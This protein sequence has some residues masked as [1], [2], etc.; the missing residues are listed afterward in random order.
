MQDLQQLKNTKFGQTK[1]GKNSGY[2]PKNKLQSELPELV[3]KKFG[4]LRVLTGKIIRKESTGKAQ[5]E[6]VCTIC[7][8][9]SL[10]DYTSLTTLHA[11]CRKCAK[12]RKIPK[13]LMQRCISAKQRCTNKNDKAYSRYGAREIKFMF[14]SPTEMGLWIVKN[15]GL[16]KTKQIDRIDNN[17]NYERGNLRLSTA[18]QNLCHTQKKPRSP[19]IHYIR[20]YHK[21]IKYADK[22]ITKLISKGFSIK[23]IAERQKKFPPNKTHAKFSTLETP[24]LFIASQYKDF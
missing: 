1:D 5:L 15:L 17:G 8:N 20:L 7:G 6:T 24:D 21:E 22:T 16:D 9:V 2:V 13:W 23:E 18:E 14:N 4:K 12:P 19:S 3:G 11:G 10:K